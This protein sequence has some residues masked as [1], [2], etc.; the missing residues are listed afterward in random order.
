[1]YLYISEPKIKALDVSSG[2]SAGIAAELSFKFPFLEGKLS[3]VNQNEL[4]GQL[5]KVV[6]KLKKS[7]LIPNFDDIIA[8]EAPM[9]VS[10]AGHAGRVVDKNAFW[11]VMKGKHN[12]L[13]LAGSPGYAIGRPPERSANISPSTDPVGALRGVFKETGKLPFPPINSSLSSSLS[14]AWQE[15]VRATFLAEGSMPRVEGIAIFSRS[16]VGDRRQ[17]RR[18][19][20]GGLELLV[21]GSPLYVKQI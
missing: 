14:Y 2:F 12:G 13:L 3:G 5:E 4:V 15:L 9:L 19:N 6:A 1:M 17:L 21:I 11:C 18:V 10:F 7:E 8:G 16:V 20:S